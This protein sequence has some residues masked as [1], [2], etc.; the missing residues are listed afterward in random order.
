MNVLTPHLAA[1]AADPY[2]NY[3]LQT[4]TQALGSNEHVCDTLEK[5]FEGSWVALSCN[6]FASNVMEKIIKIS[7]ETPSCSARRTIIDELVS[8]NSHLSIIIVDNY[9][10][11]VLQAIIDSCNNSNEFRKIGDRVRPLLAS[12]PYGHKIEGK[13]KA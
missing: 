10:N 3:V 6:K 13:L 5:A 7:A 2:G 1:L 12:S 8:N 4:I 9:G 11:F